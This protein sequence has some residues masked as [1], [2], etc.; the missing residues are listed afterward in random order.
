MSSGSVDCKRPAQSKES[1]YLCRC[2]RSLESAMA[3]L[4]SWFRSSFKNCV[5]IPAALF[6]MFGGCLGIAQQP[7]HHPLP[8][9]GLPAT[10]H[11]PPLPP[12]P[13]HQG[14]SQS[15]NPTPPSLNSST[16]MAF[17]PAA[18]NSSGGFVSGRITGIAVDPTNSSTIYIAAHCCPK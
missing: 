1:P 12:P 5:F 18:L 11:T 14:A 8:P 6:L 15:A 9:P 16:W 2:L 17:G 7:R 3:S 4:C 10:T 13:A